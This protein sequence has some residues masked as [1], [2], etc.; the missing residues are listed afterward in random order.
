M[1]AD[2]MVI[3]EDLIL[4]YLFATD[5]QIQK[6]NT[7]LQTERDKLQQ[8]ILP[9]QEKI[10]EIQEKFD[11]RD[12][13]KDLTQ[14]IQDLREFRSG[15]EQR[16]LDA[17]L[18]RQGRYELI[19][20]VRRTRRVIVAKFLSKFGQEKFNEVAEIP[21]IK[22]EKAV[23]ETEL[24]D[25]CDVTVTRMRVDVVLADGPAAAEGGA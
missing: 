9:L 10:L 12:D 6:Q 16:A 19:E 8:E 14:N 21:V 18:E 15:L 23:G 24:A 5:A 20:R 2:P 7:K 3:P 11:G 4:E 17:K 1:K 25:C 13:I 22:A